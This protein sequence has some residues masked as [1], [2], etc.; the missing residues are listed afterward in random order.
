VNFW[1]AV[2]FF[3]LPGDCSFWKAE[4]VFDSKTRCEEVVSDALDVFQEN[5]EVAAGACLKIRMTQV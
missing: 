1:V 5:A 2:V 3:C 4:Q